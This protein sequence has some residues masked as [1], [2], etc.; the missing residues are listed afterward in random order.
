MRKNMRIG[1]NSH[2]TRI[3]FLGKKI[4]VDSTFRP[5]LL[6]KTNQVS[7]FSGIYHVI[8]TKKETKAGTFGFM[9]F[10]GGIKKEIWDEMG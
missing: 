1:Y 2:F 6:W 4:E 8:K 9:M 3:F 10:S 7:R 5:W